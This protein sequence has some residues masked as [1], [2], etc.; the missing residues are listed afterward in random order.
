MCTLVDPQIMLS[1]NRPDPEYLPNI[2]G[3]RGLACLMVLIYHVSLQV[4]GPSLFADL[5]VYFERLSHGVQLFFILSAFTLF[6][7]ANSWWQA[8]RYPAMSFYI[9]RAFR[10]LPLWWFA[11]ALDFFLIPGRVD[12]ESALLTASFLFGMSQAWFY[13]AT[14]PAGWSLF[15]E[16]TFYLLFPVW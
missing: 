8:T 6:H 5:S 14:I 11:V 2:D 1:N 10:I 15:V 16:E 3:M 13:F 7:T 4:E 12:V 9:R